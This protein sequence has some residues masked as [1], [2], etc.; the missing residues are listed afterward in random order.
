MSSAP[1]H[2]IEKIVSVVNR[3]DRVTKTGRKILKEAPNEPGNAIQPV[4]LAS[5]LE[6]LPSVMR[7][8]IYLLKILGFVEEVEQINKDEFG[9]LMKISLSAEGKIARNLVS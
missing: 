2:D 8:E 3:L 6:I 7:D 5:K 4:R 1:E 9:D